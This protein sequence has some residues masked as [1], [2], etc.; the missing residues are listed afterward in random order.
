MGVTIF[1]KF[2]VNHWTSFC[3]SLISKTFDFLKRNFE[4]K[5]SFWG[6]KLSNS[7]IMTPMIDSMIITKSIIKTENEPVLSSEKG[8]WSI[9]I[10]KELLSSFQFTHIPFQWIGF[11]IGSPGILR[12]C[13]IDFLNRS[14][15]SSRLWSTRGREVARFVVSQGSSLILKRQGASS[16]LQAVSRLML[17]LFVEPE[18]LFWLQWTSAWCRSEVI[19]VSVRS[20][21]SFLCCKFV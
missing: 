14:R 1:Y 19:A 16:G 6:T 8:K 21:S 12:G 2:S 5:I 7:F 15:D 11:A 9:L 4:N 13:T 20:L 17:T 3:F 18:A 10:S